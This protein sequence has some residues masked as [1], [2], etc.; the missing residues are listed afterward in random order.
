MSLVKY[1]KRDG[2]GL[3]LV[4]NPPVNAFSVGVPRGIMEALAEAA[5]DV[6]VAAVVVAGSGRTFI[7]GADIKRLG[8]WPEGEPN[9]RN[10]ID[11]CEASPK[12]VVAAIHGHALGGGLE[13]AMACH[14]RVCTA[15]ARLGQPEVKIGVPPGAGGTQRL[16]RLVG[17]EKALRMILS[18]TPIIGTEAAQIGLVDRAVEGDLI[19]E[20]LAFAA[21]RAAGGGPHPKAR[22]REVRLDDP[23][24]FDATRKQI[25]RRARGMRAPYACI[26]C[27]EA[28]VQLPFDEGIA[29]EYEVF[30]AQVRSPEAAALRH[31]F[32]AERQIARVPG[33]GKDI[34]A[35]DV[36]EGAV[37]GAGTMGRSR[38]SARWRP[39]SGT[40]PPP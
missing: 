5:G 7:A 34:A 21:E 6:E 13:L 19:D 36:R 18:G 14:Y 17:A 29:R 2:V 11:R 28:A 30:D 37:I 20:A 32:F 23:G 15:D 12:P 26:E 31:V 24:I 25:E 16:P 40:T 22:D 4:D 33:I 8:A 35:R 3:V 38:S 39:S 10:A 1:E 27:V 9:L